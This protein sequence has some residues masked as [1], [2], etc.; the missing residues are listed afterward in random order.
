MQ[1]NAA[2][3]CDP[4]HKIHIYSQFSIMT[5]TEELADEVGLLRRKEAVSHSVRM[6]AAGIHSTLDTT[7]ILD[8]TIRELSRVLELDVCV[9]WETAKDPEK[10]GIV[11]TAGVKRVSREEISFSSK[12]V[13]KVFDHEDPVLLDPDT[14]LLGSRSFSISYPWLSCSPP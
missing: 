13:Q 9:V 7:T 10:L 3:V 12:E 14:R 8:T 6:L 4:Q 5:K 2:D 11:C 1:L